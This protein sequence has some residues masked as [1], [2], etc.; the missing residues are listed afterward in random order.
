MRIEPSQRDEARQ[1]ARELAKIA[2]TG[3]VLPG[4]IT[5]RH[6]RCGKPS[7]ACHADPPRLHGPYWHWTR[8]IA[9]KT[10]GKYL[11]KT[12]AGECQRWIENDRR[13][14]ELLARLEAIGIDRLE[15]A[16][17]PD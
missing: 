14:R 13:I 3:D 10:V 2:R 8:K 5:E 9:N 4:S 6:T 17:P 12:Q 15:A 16:Q 1:I 11:H 7:C